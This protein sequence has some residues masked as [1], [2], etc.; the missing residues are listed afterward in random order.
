VSTVGP[1]RAG[2]RLAAGAA[3]PT[4]PDGSASVVIWIVADR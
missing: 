3:R 2:K 1:D 4:Q